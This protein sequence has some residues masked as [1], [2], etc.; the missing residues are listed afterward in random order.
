MARLSPWMSEA[1]KKR[2]AEALANAKPPNPDTTPDE[3]PVVRTGKGLTD[4]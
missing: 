3:P 2:A 1:D 4:G